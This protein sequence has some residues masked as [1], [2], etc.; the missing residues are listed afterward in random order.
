MIPESYSVLLHS[1]SIII[2]KFSID[3]LNIKSS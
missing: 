3:H 1:K 2:I